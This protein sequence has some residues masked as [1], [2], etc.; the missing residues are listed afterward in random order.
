[1]HALEGKND[2]LGKNSILKLMDAVDKFVPV[3]ERDLKSPFLLPI[4]RAVSVPGRGQVLIGT[5][6][7]GILK[8]GDNFEVIGYN[9]NIKTTAIE[10]HVFK[11]SVNE[12]KAGDNVGILARGIKPGS[13]QRG[14]AAIATNS[15]QQTNYVETSVYMLNKNEGGRAKP[16]VTG[17]IQP[18]FTKTITIDAYLQV[19]DKEMIMPGDYATVNLITRRPVVLLP[20][21]RFTVREQ[22]AFTIFNGVVSKALPKQEENIKGFNYHP[23]KDF[24]HRDAGKTKKTPPVSGTGTAKKEPSG[25]KSTKKAK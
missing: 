18:L 4:E 24:V 14:M 15:V 1:M 2:E 10:I 7:R 9:E 8:K 16:I 20:G 11:N 5:V 17:Y 13:I 22:G 23:T 3:P 12:A 6:T 21:D 25:D 19:K